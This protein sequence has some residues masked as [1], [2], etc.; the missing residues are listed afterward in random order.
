M[1]LCVLLWLLADAHFTSHLSKVVNRNRL[2]HR[3]NNYV[4]VIVITALFVSLCC[5]FGLFSQFFLGFLSIQLF[6][7]FYDSLVFALFAVFRKMLSKNVSAR[8]TATLNF[9]HTIV[10]D[11]RLRHLRKLR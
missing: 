1:H 11:D 4:A 10:G 5:E 6:S 8:V 2:M 7:S 3:F 9:V